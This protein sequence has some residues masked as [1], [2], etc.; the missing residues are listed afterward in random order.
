MQTDLCLVLKIF[1]VTL[2]NLVGVHIMAITTS[3]QIQHWIGSVNLNDG[4][5]LLH[6]L[7]I[8]VT[9]GLGI[10]LIAGFLRH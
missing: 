8:P 4:H 1:S 5:S 7:G 6:T 9:S 10:G 2:T 3:V